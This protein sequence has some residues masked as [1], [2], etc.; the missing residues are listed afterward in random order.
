M[1]VLFVFFVLFCTRYADA[2]AL[3]L[4]KGFKQHQF[5]A[6]LAEYEKIGVWQVNSNRTIIKMLGW[7]E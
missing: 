4:A 1:I 3:V 2:L 6:S 5:E 7:E